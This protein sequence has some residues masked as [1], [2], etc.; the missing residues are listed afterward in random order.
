MRADDISLEYFTLADAG[1]LISWFSSSRLLFQFDP[2]L[3]YPLTKQQ[4]EA[5]FIDYNRRG[6]PH[7]AFRVVQAELGPIGHIELF[8]TD[9]HN[10]FGVISHVLIGDEKLRGQGYGTKALELICKFGF[11]E[12][13]LHRLE[14]L[15][16]AFNTPAISC[17]EKVGFRKEGMFREKRIFDGEYQS[18]YLMGLLDR[19]YFELNPLTS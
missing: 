13:R 15:V 12:L 14:L 10:K 3:T 8:P 17:Y 1:R 16:M 6:A 4:L 19:E 2:N 11:H 5:R 7:F 18:T 9:Y